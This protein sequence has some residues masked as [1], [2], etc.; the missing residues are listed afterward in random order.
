M[1]AVKITVEEV[2]R[3]AALAHLEFTDSEHEELAGQL[4]D[5]L[6][7]VEKLEALD[8]SSVGPTSHLLDSGE[9][10]RDDA[11]QPSLSEEEALSSAP[12]P[13]DGHFKVPRVI[14]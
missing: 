14:G 1:P 3:I 13:G 10:F 11:E 2:R 5:I 7:Y 4:S 12:E 8:V 9:A 6:S